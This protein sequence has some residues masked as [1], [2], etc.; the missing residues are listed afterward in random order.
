MRTDVQSLEERRV[1]PLH[2]GPVDSNRINDW[3]RAIVLLHAE[4]LNA[5]LVRETLNV[6]LK[7][8]EDIA[9]AG[10]QVNALVLA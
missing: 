7:F 8:E 6:L 5:S 2:A 9:A 4:E 1:R 3:A 10:P